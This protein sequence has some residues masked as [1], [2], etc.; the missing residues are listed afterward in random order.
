MNIKK[1]ISL[2]SPLR[3]LYHFLR[4]VVAFYVY[5]NPARDM[6]VIGITGTKGKTTT[7]NIIAKGL[8]DAGEKVFMFSTVNYMIGDDFLENNLK[9]TSPS[10]FVL[11]KL[12]KKAKNAGC[13]YA[14]IETS[15][16]SIFYNRNYGIDFDI[17]AL[18]NI[19]QDHLDL[20]KTMENYY[21]IKLKLFENLVRYRRKNGIKKVSVVNI[22]SQYSSEFLNIVDDNKYTYGLSNTAQIKA[23]NITYG[24]DFTEFEIKI[25]GNTVK[26]KTKLKGE[27][28]IYNIL[29]SVCVLISQK[30]PLDSIVNT[31]ATTNGI[32]GRLEE[33]SNNKGIK[34]FVDYAHTEDSLK[35]VLETVRN[36]TG[37]GKIITVFGATG[38]RDKSKR[39]KM[40]K[41]VN[42]LSDSIILTDDDTYTENS[43]SIINDVAKGIKRKEGDNFWIVP[44]REDAIRTALIMAQ[45]SDL[46]I[47]AGKGAET[48]QITNK[49]PINWSDVGTVK[50]ILKEIEDNELVRV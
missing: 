19:S 12:L 49:G 43:L 38:D 34:I 15:S 14:V 50:K 40:G 3:V 48:L 23:Q 13:K 18:T 33:V 36:I 42:E 27:F 8:R 1:L 9:M 47:I 37:I 6:I 22:D 39:P 10:P 21:K 46:I 32:P 4:G 2:D 29:A 7:T 5:G 25:P 44:D 28:N 45:K 24:I 26:M 31:I 30:V 35:N 20:H 16:H 11:Q 17:V 41:V